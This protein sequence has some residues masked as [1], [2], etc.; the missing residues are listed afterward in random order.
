VQFAALFHRVEVCRLLIGIGVQ[1]DHSHY[2]NSPLTMAVWLGPKTNSKAIIDTF[3]FL[4]ENTQTIEDNVWTTGYR[5]IPHTPLGFIEWLW[6]TGPSYMHEDGVQALKNFCIGRSFGLLHD[7]STRKSAIDFLKR[8]VT[9]HVIRQMELN[10]IN[11]L[12]ILFSCI[13]PLELDSFD[14]GKAFIDVLLYAKVDMEMLVK[15]SLQADFTFGGSTE[16]NRQIIFEFTE[17]L[18]W[19]LG[20]RWKYDAT[21]PGFLVVSEFSILGHEYKGYC[22]LGDSWPYVSQYSYMSWANVEKACLLEMRRF[23]RGMA[24]KARKEFKRSGQRR[25]RSKMPGS[26]IS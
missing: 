16:V 25:V 3:R 24:A 5:P 2:G 9:P 23:D 21:E 26:W 17:E 12:D 10:S 15:R 11:W 7:S 20:W 14:L 6:A 22:F 13:D 4:V 8:T 1:E 19:I 18:G